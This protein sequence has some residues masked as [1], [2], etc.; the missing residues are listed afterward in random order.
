M[1]AH[2]SIPHHL[3]HFLHAKPDTVHRQI[4]VPIV[5]IAGEANVVVDYWKV[6]DAM[7]VFGYHS[8]MYVT[9]VLDLVRDQPGRVFGIQE[10]PVPAIP[11]VKPSYP[12]V[13]VSWFQLVEVVDEHV[14]SLF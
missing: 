14:R 4:L 10:S 7:G 5:S 1:P 12:V 2:S 3:H 6:D 8:L 9:N 11:Q 13:G